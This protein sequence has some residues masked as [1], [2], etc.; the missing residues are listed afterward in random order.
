MGLKASAATDVGYDQG[1]CAGSGSGVRV[2]GES[3]MEIVSISKLSGN[4]VYY[5]A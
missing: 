3:D 1:A 5:S 2:Q 4:E